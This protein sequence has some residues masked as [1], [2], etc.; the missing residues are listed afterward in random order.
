MCI[1]HGVQTIANVEIPEVETKESKLETK[2]TELKETTKEEVATYTLEEE[3]VD[4]T[5]PL[6][7]SKENLEDVCLWVFHCWTP[8]EMRRPM[9][10]FSNSF[11]PKILML[12]RHVP[13]L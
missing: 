6:E 4:N 12:M 10:S 7:E 3:I 5:M 2:I 8:R 13:C 11:V 9:R 1:R